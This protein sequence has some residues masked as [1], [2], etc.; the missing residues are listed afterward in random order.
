[1]S[2]ETTASFGVVSRSIQHSLC[3]LDATC[4]TINVIRLLLHRADAYV[5]SA[6]VQTQTLTKKVVA[7]GIPLRRCSRRQ[8]RPGLAGQHED[9][10]PMTCYRDYLVSPICL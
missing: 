1:M 3:G 7:M 2:K 9:F 5:A 4:R 8:M 6:L 10:D